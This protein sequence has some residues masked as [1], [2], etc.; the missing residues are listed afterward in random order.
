MR[1]VQAVAGA[2]TCVLVSLLG[3]AL[4]GAAGGWV[5]GLGAAAYGPALLYGGE[6][7]PA[8]LAALLALAALSLLAAAGT[9]ATAY[10]A[11]GLA[12]GAA[13]LTDARM[14]LLAPFAL[15]WMCS[16]GRASPTRLTAFALPPLAACAAGAAWLQAGLD[17]PGAAQAMERLALTW[18]GAEVL[19]D[20]DPYGPG[21]AA[22]LPAVLMWGGPPAVPFGLLAPLAV[23]GVLAVAREPVGRLLLCFAAAASAAALLTPPSA[24]D[25]L[26]LA[27]G[28][29]PLAA[30]A[31]ACLS[32]GPRK[33]RACLAGAAAATG[34]LVTVGA[35]GVQAEARASHHRW[36]GD[37]YEQL[38]M[39]SHAVS[40]YERALETGR[41]P[42]QAYHSLARLYASAGAPA[43][44]IGVYRQLAERRPGDSSVQ[45]ALG[46]Y[47]MAAGRAAEAEEA[48]RTALATGGEPGNVNGWLGDA[49]QARGEQEGAVIAYRQALAA[50]PDSHRV[51]FEL[52]SML[53]LTGA[54][55][56]A[57]GHYRRLLDR[58]AWEIRAGWRLAEILSREPG[59]RG[60]AEAL[61]RRV[62]A[63]RPDLRPALWRLARLLHDAG[64]YG[65]ARAP[66]ERLRS[67]DPEDFRAYRLLASV[68]EHLGQTDRAAEAFRTYQRLERQAQIHRAVSRQAMEAAQRVA[69]R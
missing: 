37:S 50:R 1:W 41:A 35:G 28:L 2:A 13:L 65:E 43:R 45:A 6:T 60:E 26:A 42:D 7:V 8:T 10:A 17:L 54:A 68:H 5:S 33:R 66:L 34:L 46:C 20:L 63:K 9:S 51:R 55:A 47:L 15:V 61:L 12:A 14:V 69:P 16:T 27:F 38:N 58:P 22:G 49:L 32:R 31:V 57:A 19:P 53:E 59:G 67:L 44:S 4:A 3:A 40:A 48:L 64:R 30:P 11:A 25:R 52:A 18:H 23:A 39:E 24:R 29:W 62:L 21:Y 56:E 36:L